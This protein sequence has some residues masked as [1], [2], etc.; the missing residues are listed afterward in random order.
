MTHRVMGISVII[1]RAKDFHCIQKMIVRIEKHT[2]NVI[3]NDHR[4][5]E[6]IVSRMF[7]IITVFPVN[8]V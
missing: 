1:P 7:L 3:P 4:R 8:T 2:I 6:Y 5:L